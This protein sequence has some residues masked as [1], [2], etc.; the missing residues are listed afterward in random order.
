MY[1][2]WQVGGGVV[3]WRSRARPAGVIPADGCVDLILREEQVLVAGPSTRWIA[4]LRA[5]EGGSLGLRMPPGT[6]SGVLRADLAELAD[7]LL[8]LE[9]VVGRARA[10]VLRDALVADDDSHR[11][12]RHLGGLTM[13]AIAESGWSDAVRRHARADVPARAAAARTGDSDRTMRRLMLR[14]FGYGYATLVRIERA[15]RAQE[16]LQRGAPV[17]VA[18]A[19]AG[20]ADQSHLSREFRRLVGASPGQFSARAA[21]KST[22]LPSGSRTV[23]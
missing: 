8:P 22:A 16:L 2:E 23:A 21:K 9:D 1:S 4:T 13:N 5:G 11:L 15:R 14:R 3:L 19:R 6:A 7:R 10:G 12:S 17:A 20:F 18:A